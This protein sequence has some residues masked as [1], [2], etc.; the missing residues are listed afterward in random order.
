M[1]TRYLDGVK[2]LQQRFPSM[3]GSLAIASLLSLNGEI[4]PRQS[5]MYALWVPDGADLSHSPCVLNITFSYTRQVCVFTIYEQQT[6]L[7]ASVNIQTNHIISRHLD[8]FPWLMTD[9]GH[10]SGS[11]CDD[12]RRVES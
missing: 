1:D 8:N 2:S 4:L 12:P 9:S 7:I 10:I 3:I 11:L 5:C 6:N